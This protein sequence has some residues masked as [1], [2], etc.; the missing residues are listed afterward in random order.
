MTG[1]TNLFDHIP[2]DLPEELVTTLLSA[3]GLRIETIVS[4][5]HCSPSGFWYDQPQHEWVLLLRGA[6]RIQFEGA[7]G[8]DLRPGDYINIAAHLRHR[9]E[10]TTADEPTV[11]LAIHYGADQGV[12]SPTDL[13]FG[14]MSMTKVQAD[15]TSHG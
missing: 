1:A 7:A 14:G 15:E 3:A 13:G 2:A 9:V 5:G 12:Q 10:W 6:A 11:W 4:R 8:V